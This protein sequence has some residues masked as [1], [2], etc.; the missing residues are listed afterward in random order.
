MKLPRSSL[1]VSISADHQAMLTFLASRY[2]SKVEVT[3]PR[4]I[5]KFRSLIKASYSVSMLMEDSKIQNG[6]IFSLVSILR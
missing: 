6:V 2:S 3:T 1:Y 5:V 4:K